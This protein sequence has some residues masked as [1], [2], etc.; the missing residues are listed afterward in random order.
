MTNRPISPALVVIDMQ[1]AFCDPKGTLGLLGYDV[2][3]LREPIPR[4]ARLIRAARELNVPVLFTRS[5]YRPD[6]ADGGILLDELF[7]EV[8]RFNGVTAGSWDARIIDLL[9]P[10]PE[11]TVIDK[12][13]Y[14]AFFRT[15]L[16]DVLKKLRV[17]TLLICGVTTT[18]CV[19]STARDACFRD[20]RVCVVSDATAEVDRSLHDAG[21][22]I[23]ELWFGY[24]VDSSAAIE[25]LETRHFETRDK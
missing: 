24:V 4:V 21:L 16:E 23:L 15:R 19:E 2:A 8:K 9:E 5:V 18:G 13:R 7:C 11:E 20:F 12:N 6:Y 25:M 10:Q 22:R 1:N 3:P 17:D 14:S